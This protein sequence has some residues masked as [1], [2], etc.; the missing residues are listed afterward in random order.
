MYTCEDTCPVNDTNVCCY[1]CEAK[2]YCGQFCPD[3][4]GTC[5]KSTAAEMPDEEMACT[6]FQQEQLT[7]IQNMISLLD[8]KK[9]IEAREKA[10]K[11]QLKAA[12]ERH[13]IKAFK[14]DEISIAY[15]AETVAVSIDSAKVKKKYPQV[16]EE[17]QKSSKRS[18][19]VKIT[20]KGG[21]R[22]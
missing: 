12:M 19:Y 22:E 4:P 16:F 17:C 20:V 6:V 21:D 1:S 5:K 7:V 14:T 10:M 11:D 3:E 13:N 2:S 9:A 18:A 15:V 8:Q